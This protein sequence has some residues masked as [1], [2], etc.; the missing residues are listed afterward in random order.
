MEEIP[1]GAASP[2]RTPGTRLDSWKEIAAYLKRDVRTVQRWEK[3]EGMPVHRHQ[4]DKLG[5]VYAFPDELD[6]WT[7][8]RNI[9]V[10]KDAPSAGAIDEN[11]STP[12]VT[13][14]IVPR[15]ERRFRARDVATLVIAAAACAAVFLWLRGHSEIFWRNPLSGARF[16]HLTDFDGS[17]RAAA[18]SPD[19]RLVAFLSDRDGQTDVWVTQIDTG[20]FHNLTRGRV[21]QLVNPDVRTI[22]FLPDGSSVAFWVRHTDA[23]GASR[24]GVWSVPALGGDPAPYL[25][26]VA[27]FSWSEDGSRLVYHTAGPGDP[28]FVRTPGQDGDRQ[29]L[30]AD[31]G[32]HAHFPVWSPDQAFIYF[33]QGVVPDPMDVFRISPAGGAAEQVTRQQSR[34]SYPVMINPRTLLYLATDALDEGPWLYGMDVERRV[35]HRLT[36]GVDAYVSLSSSADGR[37]L[38]LTKANPKRTLWRLRI[39]DPLADAAAA[40][41]I[42]LTTGNGS[43]PRFGP[44]FLIYV[45]RTGT[46]D[47]IWK[48]AG[49]SSAQLWTAPDATV[50]GRPAI[51]PGGQRIAF[52]IE[53]RGRRQ[54]CVIN[55]DGTEFRVVTSALDLSGDPAWAPPGRGVTT[56]ASVDGRPRLF[57]IGLDGSPTPLMQE[58]SVDPVWSPDGTFVVYSGA[59]I[60]TTLP[61]KAATANGTADPRVRLTLPRGA[62]RAAFLGDGHRLVVMRGDMQH[63]DLWLI[64]LDTGAEK[65][66]TALPPDFNIR[67][68]DISPDGR[69]LVL[70]RWQER[71]DIVLVEPGS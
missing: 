67:E 70:E 45:S 62:R 48:L 30:T 36:S 32:L 40:A 24:V 38:V 3:R 22:G 33:V 66:L 64:D 59:D 52:S 15:R 35:A 42:P 4:H 7:S 19:G 71:S 26:S 2:S 12:A 28:T 41:P 43:A 6:G 21:T 16:Q 14:P 44:G 20:L 65:R 27:E 23:G 1:S 51:E 49:G 58:Y 29:I 37:R 10:I 5:S 13:A 34:V 53:I 68:F 60:G 46:R 39:E 11:T 47:T 56:A 55:A 18:I 54:L 50:I 63:K 57:T 8:S 61:L 31:S 9:S 25:D 69:D 17:E